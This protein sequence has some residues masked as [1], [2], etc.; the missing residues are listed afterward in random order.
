[1]ELL[2][3]ICSLLRHTL[4]IEFGWPGW[5]VSLLPWDWAIEE[6]A[7]KGIKPEA[8]SWKLAFSCF[9]ASPSTQTPPPPPPFL[10]DHLPF[11][12]LQALWES[13]DLCSPLNVL[14]LNKFNFISSGLLTFKSILLEYLKHKLK[15]WLKYNVFAT[16]FKL[17]LIPHLSGSRL[18]LS[19]PSGKEWWLWG[20][21]KDVWTRQLLEPALNAVI[22]S[23]LTYL[24]NER[25]VCGPPIS[26]KGHSL[27]Y[28]S[29][30][31]AGTCPKM[32]IHTL[33]MC[34]VKK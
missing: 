24:L 8:V 3:E 15:P 29:K 5:S 31:I 7:V 28:L 19:S 22:S 14:F 11:N 26:W 12:C 20:Q 1:M 32:F 33:G 13:W 4:N 34:R 27:C 23:T 9:P 16:N 10:C 30:K 6:G 25:L 2:F 18:H 21:K 17:R